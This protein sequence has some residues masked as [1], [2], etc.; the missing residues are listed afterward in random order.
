[1]AHNLNEYL[2]ENECRGFQPI[3]HY[4]RNGDFV[5][6]YFGNDPCRAQRVDD[7]LTVYLSD[8]TGELVGCKIKGVKHLLT[9]LGN[10]GVTI[11]DGDLKLG[12]FFCLGKSTAKDEEQRRRYEELCGLAKD[13]PLKRGEL[14]PT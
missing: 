13:V 14:L 2:G 1:M 4:F 6:Y 10:F 3:P 7:L 9:S 5:S 11:Q 12:F 8:R